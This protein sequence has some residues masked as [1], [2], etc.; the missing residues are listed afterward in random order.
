MG[1]QRVST[2]V[3]S[4][5]VDAGDEVASFAS[6]G[7]FREG[8]NRPLTDGLLGDTFWQ[9]TQYI[10]SGGTEPITL[11]LDRPEPLTSVEIALSDA[12]FWAKDIE[13]LVDGKVQAQAT[14]KKV[15]GYQVIPLSG[16]PAREVV[17][18][19]K[20][21][22]PA[23]R[24]SMQPLATIDEVRLRRKWSAPMASLTRPGGIVKYPRGKG[25]ILL[26]QVRFDGDDLPEN[27]AKKKQIFASLL[28]NLGS[29]FT[30]GP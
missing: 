18:R 8:A 5:V 2:K 24:A 17:I 21:T 26:N 6:L 16:A 29:S 11:T 3:F 1:L 25:G 13:V 12:Y 19:L 27:L 14:L 22:Y 23:Q 4:S 15:T 7:A 28:R 30:G 20:S 9:Y 10:S